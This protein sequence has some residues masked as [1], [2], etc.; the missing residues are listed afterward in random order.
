M[1]KCEQQYPSIELP[2][3]T[4]IHS[5]NNCELLMV[6]NRTKVYQMR[7]TGGSYPGRGLYY[8]QFKIMDEVDHHHFFSQTPIQLQI[9][10]LPTKRIVC[11]ISDFHSLLYTPTDKYGFRKWGSDVDGK[12]QLCVTYLKN[13]NEKKLWIN[14]K[15]NMDMECITGIGYTPFNHLYWNARENDQQIPHINDALKRIDENGDPLKCSCG[16]II[17]NI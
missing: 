11:E 4:C 13:G 3:D 8:S 6:V 7:N 14:I 9:V 2:P 17:A 16:N 15:W 5:S 12:D 10:H 1:Q